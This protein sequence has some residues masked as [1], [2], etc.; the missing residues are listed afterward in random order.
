MSLQTVVDDVKGRVETLTTQGQK[1]A[2]ISL[3]TLKQS[4]EIVADKF[5][6][7]VKTESAAAK[8]LYTVTKLSFDKAIADGF[9]AFTAAPISYLPPK[10]KFITV[11]TD[12]VTLVSATGDELYKTFKTGFSSIQAE[13]KGE[14]A[15]VKKV[16]AAAKKATGAA[17]KAAKAV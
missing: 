9:K 4:G 13:L 17:K 5:Q 7:L 10:D 8:E 3:D 6:T 1:V 14:A 15:P 12:T 11:Y 16:K 2:Q